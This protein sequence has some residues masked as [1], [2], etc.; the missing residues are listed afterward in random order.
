M[1]NY[2][3]NCDLSYEP[4]D[5]YRTSEVSWMVGHY[6]KVWEDTFTFDD[7]RS[8]SVRVEICNPPPPSAR[9]SP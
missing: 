3:T 4:S 6:L 8:K 2:E 1:G 9:A 5:M 7:Y